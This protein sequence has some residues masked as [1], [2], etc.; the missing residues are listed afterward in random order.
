MGGVNSWRWSACLAVPLALSAC[1][2][3][4]HINLGQKADGSPRS[5]IWFDRRDKR[6][7]LMQQRAKAA[8]PAGQPAPATRPAV[9]PE[10]LAGPVTVGL[11]R[12]GASVVAG[13]AVRDEEI[14]AR[15]TYVRTQRTNAHSEDVSVVTV[16][17]EPQ[18]SMDR[19]MSA[20][21]A[22]HQAG[23][24]KIGWQLV[25]SVP[26]PAAEP[27]SAALPADEG[28]LVVSVEADGTL[29]LGAE[30]VEPVVLGARLGETSASRRV[31]GLT[32]PA[33]TILAD[34]D[35]PLASVKQVLTACEAAGITAVAF[36]SP[37]QVASVP[38]VASAPDALPDLGPS[39]AF[40]N[41]RIGIENRDVDFSEGPPDYWYFQ[42]F[43]AWYDESDQTVEASTARILN[44]ERI[45]YFGNKAATHLEQMARLL[46]AVD[47]AR[48]KVLAGLAADTRRQA[49]DAA[50]GKTNLE[51]ARFYLKGIQTRV[52]KEFPPS[53]VSFPQGITLLPPDLP[54]HEDKPGEK[55]P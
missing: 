47:A 43:H 7:A 48:A 36:G 4:D 54:R 5:Q 39:E 14:L 44:T 31:Q 35:A 49:L 6:D 46:E 3:P 20:M 52:T 55:R 51:T 29:K 15:L 18:V 8:P 30:L 28:R 33:V 17:A 16:L 26:L 42:L 23:F 37:V 13:K 34:R 1:E 53:S 22:G 10:V 19:V 41:W 21:S 11:R 12:D 25:Q 50:D 38:V 40:R 45:K 32:P 9:P 27:L 24:N 2:R